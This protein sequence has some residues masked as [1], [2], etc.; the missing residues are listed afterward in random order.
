MESVNSF[1]D[2]FR[3]QLTSS[4]RE[5]AEAPV[6]TTPAYG[7]AVAD[8]ITASTIKNFILS[9]VFWCEGIC[10]N[11]L[12]VIWYDSIVSVQSVCALLFICDDNRQCFVSQNRSWSLWRGE[13]REDIQQQRHELGKMKLSIENRKKNSWEKND[14]GGL[15]NWPDERSNNG[16]K[17]EERRKKKK[18]KYGRDV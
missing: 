14:E 5:T 3:I 15:W 11:L 1:L 18:R 16:Y 4:D 12:Q 6:F 9:L 13:G 7:T 2:R 17:K 8:A 10:G